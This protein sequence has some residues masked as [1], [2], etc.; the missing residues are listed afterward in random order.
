[1]GFSAPIDGETA[2]FEIDSQ[3]ADIAARHRTT[4]R[5]S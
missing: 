3:L 5:V 4:G 1:M 2:Q